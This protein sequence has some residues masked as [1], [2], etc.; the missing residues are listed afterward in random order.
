MVWMLVMTLG[1]PLV[2]VMGHESCGAVADA[3]NAAGG[4]AKGCA[5]IFRGIRTDAAQAALLN[6]SH[7]V[8]G[9]RMRPATAPSADRN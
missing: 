9:V 2:V 8:A 1:V 3:I 7:C 5:S 4:K 6:D